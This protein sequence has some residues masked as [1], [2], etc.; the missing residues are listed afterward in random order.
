MLADR[1][2]D[3]LAAA[4]ASGDQVPSVPAVGLGAGRANTGPAVP[5]RLEQY[6]VRLM[7]GSV[8]LADFAGTLVGLVDA[9]GQPDRVGAVGGPVDLA[10]PPA[11]AA[12]SAGGSG[13]LNTA[14]RS[15]AVVARTGRTAIA[16]AMRATSF[17]NSNCGRVLFM[18]DLG[19]CTD[20]MAYLLAFV[21]FLLAQVAMPDLPPS[22][23]PVGAILTLASLLLAGWLAW[24]QDVR[25]SAEKKV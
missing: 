7:L 22:I 25:A 24:K 4:Q 8:G 1:L 16:A 2:R 19:I 15:V 5:A 14:A 6:P 17:L 21:C 23:D 12:G 3:A 10:L 11:S 18:L 9:A 13:S 20:P